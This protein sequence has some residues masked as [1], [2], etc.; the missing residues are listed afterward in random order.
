MNLVEVARVL[1]AG[2]RPTW[3]VCELM[4]PQ[5]A[6]DRHSLTLEAA[7]VADLPLLRHYH[8]AAREALSLIP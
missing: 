3:L 2:I 6:E 7:S 5:L 8:P 1:R 4:P